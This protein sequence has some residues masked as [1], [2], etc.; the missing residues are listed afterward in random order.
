MESQGPQRPYDDDEINLLDYWRVIW[1]CKWLIGILCSTSVVAA[2]ILGLLSPKIY[3]SRATIL[4]PKESGG[5]GFLSALG[6][7]G[8]AQQIAGVSLPSLTPNRDIFSSILKA[9]TPCYRVRRPT[10]SLGWVLLRK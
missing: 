4:I 2:M 1:K 5:S 7:S 10:P 6:A 3:E 8:I 9:L